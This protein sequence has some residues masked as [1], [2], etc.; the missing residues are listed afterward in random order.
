MGKGGVPIREGREDQGIEWLATSNVEGQDGLDAVYSAPAD[1]IQEIRTALGL[2]AGTPVTI[3]NA[4]DALVKRIQVKHAAAREKMVSGAV[5]PL[6]YLP[7]DQVYEHGFDPLVG[8]FKAQDATPLEVFDQSIEVVPTDQIVPV[9]VEYDP[10]T[11]L[12][13]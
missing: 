8:A 5:D 11:G 1:E 3:R 4:I 6:G 10:K 9:S 7:T 13:I 12:Q 2:A